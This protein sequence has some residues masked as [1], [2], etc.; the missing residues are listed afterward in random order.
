MNWIKIKNVFHVLL[1][2]ILFYIMLYVC[3][4][5]KKRRDGLYGMQKERDILIARQI[6]TEKDMYIYIMCMEN[7]R[8]REKERERE[9]ERDVEMIERQL[10]VYP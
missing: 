4:E 1:Y 6:E 3:T 7:K 9:R 2:Y 5:I 10:R 8:E